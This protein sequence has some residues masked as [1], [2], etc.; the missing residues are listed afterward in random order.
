MPSD[1]VDLEVIIKQ[2]RP[3]AIRIDH[4]DSNTTDVW[5]P[6]EAV[7]IEESGRM[8]VFITLPRRLAEDKGLV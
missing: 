8:S 3:K 7:E 4:P 5:L 6:L 2:R 1:L